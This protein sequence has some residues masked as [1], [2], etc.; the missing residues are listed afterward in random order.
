M[1]ACCIVGR[2]GFCDAARRTVQPGVVQRDG[3]RHIHGAVDNDL[4]TT[5]KVFVVDVAARRAV[6]CHH[7]RIDDGQLVARR[8]VVFDIGRLTRGV[9]RHGNR[10]VLR[11]LVI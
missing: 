6:E 3:A 2:I 4:G 1:D 10:A 9:G 11:D 8:G 7:T 5:G